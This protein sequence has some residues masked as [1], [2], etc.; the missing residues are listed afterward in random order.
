MNPGLPVQT[1]YHWP[2]SHPWDIF[3]T[4]Q[5]HTFISSLRLS[6]SHW[7]CLCSCLYFRCFTHEPHFFLLSILKTQPHASMYQN[8]F[9]PS[10]VSIVFTCEDRSHFVNW[11]ISWQAMGLISCSIYYE[12]CVFLIGEQSCINFFMTVFSWA[13]GHMVIFISVGYCRAVLHRITFYNLTSDEYGVQR[14]LI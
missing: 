6:T 8:L 9:T 4:H 5:N 7:Y 13:K 3:K 2:I 12:G 14:V 1:S 10:Y 11:F